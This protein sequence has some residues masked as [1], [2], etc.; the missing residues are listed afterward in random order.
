M[1]CL[2]EV[3]ENLR[4]TN[5][6]VNRRAATRVDAGTRRVGPDHAPLHRICKERDYYAAVQVLRAERAMGRG[7]R[8][9]TGETECGARRSSHHSAPGTPS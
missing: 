9:T 1:A 3:L 6:K 5:L 2:K 8:S 7:W 4:D